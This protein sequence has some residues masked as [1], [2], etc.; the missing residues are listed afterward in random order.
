MELGR[1]QLPGATLGECGVGARCDLAAGHG[2]RRTPIAP[3][4]HADAA[5]RTVEL[6]L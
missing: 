3:A 2:H 1:V 5:L 4:A 6:L